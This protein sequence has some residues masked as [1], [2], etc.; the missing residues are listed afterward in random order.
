MQ[1]CQL[2]WFQGSIPSLGPSWRIS[3][4]DPSSPWAHAGSSF[5]CL[6]IIWWKAKDCDF[7]RQYESWIHHDKQKEGRT[8]RIIRLLSCCLAAI[9]RFF[10]LGVR[11]IPENHQPFSF[12]MVTCLG[13]PPQQATA[14]P[15]WFLARN[16]G[17]A[18]ELVYPA[19]RKVFFSGLVDFSVLSFHVFGFVLGMVFTCYLQHSGALCILYGEGRNIQSQHLWF[20]RKSVNFSTFHLTPYVHISCIDVQHFGAWCSQH[21]GADTSQCTWYLQHFGAKTIHGA[22]YLQHL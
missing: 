18:L 17:L 21:F 11:N 22:W 6:K 2:Q 20:R 9:Y 12:A 19:I 7:H 16:V 5:S 8:T 10:H 3:S 13:D 1:L 14:V 15:H 4:I